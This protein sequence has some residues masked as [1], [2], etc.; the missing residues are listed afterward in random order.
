MKTG[1]KK[2]DTR[3]LV[4]MALFTAIVIV[5]Q[6]LGGFIRFGV[7]SISLVLVPIVVG[8]ALYGSKAGAW[9][10]FIFAVAVF[11]TGDA[12]AFFTV[13]P[14]GTIVTVFAKGI[15]AGLCSGLVYRALEK[16]NMTLAV[17]VAAVVCPIVNTGIFL[18]CCP[19]FFMDTIREWAGLF[20][21]GDNA[22]AYMFLGLA[23]GNF[24]F[25]LLVNVILGPVIVRL[26]RIGRKEGMGKQKA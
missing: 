13:N 18:A 14:F 3:Q 8:A 2:F 25:E 4:A 7:F 22:A 10:G 26:I 21:F 6:Y 24:L 15:L 12:N 19:L 20:G 1:A 9:L 16:K 11:I 23:G 5:L 17:F